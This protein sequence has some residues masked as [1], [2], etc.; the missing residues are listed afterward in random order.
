VL[1]VVAHRDNVEMVGWELSLELKAATGTIAYE[2]PRTTDSAAAL[3]VSGISV[4]DTS[5]P[6]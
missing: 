1:Q 6:S 2:W 4:G 3:L 5:V